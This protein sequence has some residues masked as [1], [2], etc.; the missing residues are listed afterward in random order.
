MQEVVSIR[1]L[2]KKVK[3]TVFLII[4]GHFGTN[5]SGTARSQACFAIM[6]FYMRLQRQEYSW[7]GHFNKL[8]SNDL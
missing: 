4:V 5:L 1:L 6:P 7:S 2:S 3:N 8:L